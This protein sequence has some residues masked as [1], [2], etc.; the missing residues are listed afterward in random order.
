MDVVDVFSYCWAF[1]EAENDT[2]SLRNLGQCFSFCVLFKGHV[3]L[4]K[5]MK[6]LGTQL[7]LKLN[8][9]LTKCVLRNS[10]IAVKWTE[11]FV[12]HKINL[13]VKASAE[14]SGSKSYIFYCLQFESAIKHVILLWVVC[15]DFETAMDVVLLD[16]VLTELFHMDFCERATW[17]SFAED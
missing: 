4:K 6:L 7:F 13:S 12:T 15:T 3:S 8:C 14:K 11:L 1:V 10:V 17:K 2:W 16:Y 5:K 9:S